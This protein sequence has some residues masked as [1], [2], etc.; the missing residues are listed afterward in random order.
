MSRAIVTAKNPLNDRALQAINRL[1]DGRIELFTLSSDRRSV[2]VDTL[3]AAAFCVANGI[4]CVKWATTYSA[5]IKTFVAGWDEA[6][7]K[8][9]NIARL[10]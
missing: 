4:D 2:E 7:A 5:A 8:M 10:N 9:G 3:E 1:N 6:H